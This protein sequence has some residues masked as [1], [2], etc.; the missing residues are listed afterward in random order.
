MGITEI[1]KKGKRS[2]LF[3]EPHFALVINNLTERSNPV[4]ET[5]MILSSEF[6]GDDEDAVK[7]RSELKAML[8]SIIEAL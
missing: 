7:N 2:R 1:G 3:E 6:W 5:E 4:V 8:T